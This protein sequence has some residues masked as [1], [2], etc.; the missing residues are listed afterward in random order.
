GNGTIVDDY[1]NSSSYDE[2]RIGGTARLNLGSVGAEFLT[3]DIARKGLIVARPFV[4]PF[5]MFPII[6]N[7][8]FQNIEIG[9]TAAV[10]FDPNTPLLIPNHLPYVEH[11]SVGL[12][13][14][15]HDSVTV[16]QD[17]A[18]IKSPLSVYGLDAS[19]MFWKSKDFEGRVYGDY[20]QIAQF[21]KG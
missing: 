18:R 4:K 13:D 21:N 1:S 8:F 19:V 17:S 2:R 10:D 5:Q 16:L 9:A 11:D 7:W 6:N 3:S 20:I 15:R 12:G 14:D